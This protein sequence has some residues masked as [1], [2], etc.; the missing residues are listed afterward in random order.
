MAEEN[1]YE[2]RGRLFLETGRDV[3]QPGHSDYKPEQPGEQ[4]QGARTF[5][6]GM[7]AERARIVAWLHNGS[8]NRMERTAMAGKVQWRSLGTLKDG[9]PR[10]WEPRVGHL[11]ITVHMHVDDQARRSSPVSRSVSN[12]TT[13]GH[14]R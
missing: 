11:R 7:A 1:S 12:A 13:S 10:G 8:A 5:E 14:L 2:R 3:P 9:T 4:T 6:A